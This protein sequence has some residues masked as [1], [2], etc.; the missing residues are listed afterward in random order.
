MNNKEQAGQPFVGSDV[1]AVKLRLEAYNE[2]KKVF[3][4]FDITDENQYLVMAL[5]GYT[6]ILADESELPNVVYM[7]GSLLQAAIELSQNSKH[8]MVS[9]QAKLALAKAFDF[10]PSS[11]EEVQENENNSSNTP[12]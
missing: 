7:L 1:D 6:T 8:P 2:V 3:D 5:N 9:L 10:N 4:E 12:A 11:K